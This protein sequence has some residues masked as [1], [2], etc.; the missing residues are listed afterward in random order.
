MSA[1]LETTE[2]FKRATEAAFVALHCL[3]QSLIAL[4]AIGEP[5]SENALLT[6]SE[7]TNHAQ[8][9]AARLKD[10]HDLMRIAQEAR[11]EASHV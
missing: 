4:R 1:D 10:A 2:G 8:T 7:A 3:G 6:M 5:S 9:L 11:M